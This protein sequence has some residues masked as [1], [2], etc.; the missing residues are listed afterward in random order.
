MNIFTRS[1]LLGIIKSFLLALYLSLIGF[2]DA[3]DVKKK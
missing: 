2:D 3:P 1:I